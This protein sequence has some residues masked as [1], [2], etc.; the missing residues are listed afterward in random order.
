MK[1]LIYLSV[2]FQESYINLLRLF[3]LSFAFFGNKDDNTDILILT[4]WPFH[5]KIKKIFNDLNIEVSIHCLNLFTFFEAAYSRLYVFDYPNINNYQKILYLDTDILITNN[6]NNILDLDIDNKLYTLME[7]TIGDPCHGIEFFD[8]TKID[9]ETP[10]FTSGI[11]L[12]NNSENIKDIFHRIVIHIK[13]DC[14]EGKPIP[15]CLDQAY[16]VYHA[17]SENIYNN[18]LLIGKCINNPIEF[19]ENTV[20][21]FMGWPGHYDSKYDK[22]MRFMNNIFENIKL[23]KDLIN[24]N[25]KIINKVYNWNNTKINFIENCI[26]RKESERS[27]DPSL[28]SEGEYNLFNNRIAFLKLNDIEYIIKFNESYTYFV[29]IRQHD[30]NVLLGFLVNI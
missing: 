4:M 26:C 23:N 28:F 17:I 7:G 15:I 10:A 19:T 5:D 1:K 25:S 9:R 8:F 14:S 29:S 2:F 3:S 18:Q 12:F 11:L 27:E 21:H 30:Y 24:N 20:N 6:I 13:K 22:M 16:I